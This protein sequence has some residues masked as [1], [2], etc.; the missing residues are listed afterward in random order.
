MYCSQCGAA[1]AEGARFCAACGAAT[2][3]PPPA[4][5]IAQ[6]AGELRR[7]RPGVVTLLAILKVLAGALWFALG[8]ACGAFASP[9]PD[10]VAFLPLAIVFALMGV[11]SFVCAYGL[12]RL[13]PFG[14][15]VQIGFSSVGLL[16]FPLQT[17]I[18]ALILVYMFRPG[19]RVLFSETPIEGL[20][21]DERTQLLALDG[22]SVVAV[23]VG[24]A[25]ACLYGLAVVGIIA[26]IAIPNL[27]N[28]I[29]RGKQKRTM[30]D[31]RSIATAIDA[32]AV[33][34]DVYPKAQ[35][36]T[37]LQAIVQPKYIRVMPTVDGWG[38]AFE[39]SSSDAGYEI[40]S[41]GKDGVGDDCTPGS[42]VRFNDEICFAD[43]E[44]TRAPGLTGVPQPSQ[45]PPA[46][47]PTPDKLGAKLIRLRN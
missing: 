40:F 2:A 44:F 26:A 10:R 13:R 7:H 19:I 1:L 43:G 31:I 6:P 46:D 38:N 8:V 18:S 28:A 34:H 22:G 11:A 17:V 39:V 47:R 41:H 20:R 42:T 16:G 36:V 9:A 27:L 33:D 37:Q 12:W 30:A 32:Y 23:V 15:Y 5:D 29:D 4:P 45:D 3:V 35:N 21:P 14:R 25:A 24:I